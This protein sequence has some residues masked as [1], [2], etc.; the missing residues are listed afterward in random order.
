ME[1]DIAAYNN[2]F[3][4]NFNLISNEDIFNYTTEQGYS[5]YKNPFGVNFDTSAPKRTYPVYYN[6]QIAYIPAS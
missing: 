6:G 2:D 5:T 1:G 3:L 4:F